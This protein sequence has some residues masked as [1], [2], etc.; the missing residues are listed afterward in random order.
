MNKLVRKLI[1]ILNCSVYYQLKK[2]LNNT[3]NSH[4]N[5]K[6]YIRIVM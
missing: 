2:N 4:I 3:I 5:L 6:K 1:H